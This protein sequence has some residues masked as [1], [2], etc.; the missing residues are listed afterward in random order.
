MLYITLN[1]LSIEHHESK[2]SVLTHTLD[3]WCGVK[4]LLFFFSEIG[5]V[6]YQIKVKEEKTNVQAKTLTL[7]TPLT[8]AVGLNVRY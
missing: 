4:R 1:E 5:N 7:H 6:T 3:S 2:Y 8:F